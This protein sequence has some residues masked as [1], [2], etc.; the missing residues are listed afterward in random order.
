MSTPFARAQFPLAGNLGYH[1]TLPVA[2]LDVYQQEMRHDLAVIRLRG[3][4][5]AQLHTFKSGEPIKLAWGRGPSRQLFYGYLSHVKPSITTSSTGLRLFCVG[6]SFWMKQHKQGLYTDVGAGD[7]ASGLAVE[8]GFDYD[9][10]PDNRLW[11]LIPQPGTSD[12]ELLATLARDIGYTMYVHQTQLRFHTPARDI[13]RLAWEAPYFVH[14]DYASR[15]ERLAIS[16]REFKPVL[17]QNNSDLRRRLLHGVNERTAELMSAGRDS[18]K[19]IMAENGAEALFDEHMTRSAANFLE[20]R[21]W[22]ESAQSAHRWH[23]KAEAVVDGDPRLRQA[24]PV[25]LDGLD[26]QYRGYWAVHRVH[27]HVGTTEEAKKTRGGTPAE[28]V[29]R[30]QLGRDSDGQS[31][32][33]KPPAH[34]RRHISLRDN[35]T[36]KQLDWQPPTVLHAGRWVAAWVTPRRMPT[37]GQPGVPEGAFLDQSVLDVIRERYGRVSCP[38]C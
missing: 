6:A 17:G 37:T 38:C 14:S 11:P 29:C 3:T 24:L 26:K 21:A 10:E 25:Y 9:V 23:N 36:G 33:G 34:S 13:H 19:A 30:L 16:L 8:Y 20:A 1:G 12:W 31:A 27:H 2:E 4:R 22:V 28:Y 15:H 35:P 5:L 7:V 18:L 32:A